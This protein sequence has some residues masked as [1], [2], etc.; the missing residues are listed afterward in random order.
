[1]RLRFSSFSWFLKELGAKRPLTA[2]VEVNM[3]LRVEC[4]LPSEAIALNP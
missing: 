2:V 3:W 1:M 4:D